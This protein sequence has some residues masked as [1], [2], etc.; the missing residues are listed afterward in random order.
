[1]EPPKCTDCGLQLAHTAGPGAGER[2][3]VCQTP[4]CSLEG[5]EFVANDA[6]TQGPGPA[7]ALFGN[8]ATWSKAAERLEASIGNDERG[9]LALAL[10]QIA[11]ELDRI[12]AV[13]EEAHK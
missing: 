3:Y 8:R 11:Y 4:G 10:W 5:T 12:A 9:E 13:L 6:A 7:I 1:M 2:G